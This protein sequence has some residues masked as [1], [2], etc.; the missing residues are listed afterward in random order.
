M[1][2]SEDVLKRTYKWLIWPLLTLSLLFLGGCQVLSIL[3]ETNAPT[4]LVPEEAEVEVP[5]EVPHALDAFEAFALE[6][7][8]ESLKPLTRG[9]YRQSPFMDMD[10]TISYRA[11]SMHHEE[12]LKKIWQ[13]PYAALSILSS[14]L[15]YTYAILQEDTAKIQVS[16]KEGPLTV[17]FQEGDRTA[18]FV[19]S[20]EKGLYGGTYRLH[21][22]VE[23][24][25][26]GRFFLPME[27]LLL[28]T[29]HK[30]IILDQEVFTFHKETAPHWPLI[31]LEEN[32]AL[33]EEGYFTKVYEAEVPK[34][35]T[36]ML[37]GDLGLGTDFGRKTS[38]DTFFLE[39]GPGHA[40]SELKED[41][42][43][44]DLVIANLENVFTHRTAVQ[45]GKIYTF[46]APRIEYL[47]VLKEGGIT[48]VNL[49][50]NHMV[51]YLQAGFDDTL[52]HLQDYGIEY[53]GTNEVVTSNIELGSIMVESYS[54]FEKDGMKVGLLGY[55]GFYDT[56]PSDQRLQ[57]DIH[58]L[59]HVEGVDYI[60]ASMHWGGQNTHEVDWIQGHLGR[61][62]IDYGVDLVYGHHPHV[63]Q[64]VEIYKG[65][66][67]YHSFGNFLFINYFSVPDPD[68]LLLEVTLTTDKEG[69]VH[70]VF[71]HHPI[72]WAGDTL[73]NHFMP[74][75][76][77]NDAH[78]ERTLGKLK[79]P[80]TDP[81]TFTEEP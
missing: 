71:T 69:R 3:G 81:M 44:A 34:D 36:M 58:T 10:N 24:D 64:E 17:T 45:P 15:S 1:K 73:R 11:L 57:Q 72:Y 75:P 9:F 59:R 55:L 39:H 19:L 63:L 47:D 18:S 70:P 38:F 76:M 80:T 79:I 67:I 68:G 50:N 35:L 27:D 61:K 56:H 40:L 49:V 8:A 14:P 29:G 20:T 74:R 13:R 60:I 26:A 6:D 51:D 46:K 31:L 30:D 25:Q 32:E 5:M 78:I 65:K 21:G 16:T 53:F 41:F 52:L 48:H 62:L 33:Y 2:V 42:Q 4:E 12:A 37:V 77:D 28:F 54:V 43:R 7:D 22:A 66:P 23:K